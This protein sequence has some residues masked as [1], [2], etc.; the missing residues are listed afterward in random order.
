M[1]DA[2]KKSVQKYFY[3]GIVGLVVLIIGS[4]YY[5]AI[6]LT[7]CTIPCMLPSLLV[8]TLVMACG[9]TA[10]SRFF[11]GYWHIQNDQLAKFTS[12]VSLILP[13]LAPI[14]TLIL[15]LGYRPISYPPI[16]IIELII[17]GNLV[18]FVGWVLWGIMHILWG[19]T[20]ASLG[21][22]P[23]APPLAS[24]VGVFFVGG[25]LLQLALLILFWHFG[26]F[27]TIQLLGYIFCSAVIWYSKENL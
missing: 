21:K 9:T 10:A 13:W 27:P 25:A 22:K 14:G 12:R 7:L 23:R 1:Q 16:P 6:N 24:F 5:D 3:I 4:L 2:D 20:F 26:T 17:I 11:I 8:A 15:I 18:S 19:I